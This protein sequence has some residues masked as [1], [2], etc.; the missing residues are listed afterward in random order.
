MTLFLNRT[1]FSTVFIIIII[2]FLFFFI[3]IFWLFSYIFLFT[4][5]TIFNY[6]F[7]SNTALIHCALVAKQ[8][9]PH[10]HNIPSLV[11]PWN[12]CC[13]FL[14]RRIETALCVINRLL[15]YKYTVLK[16]NG[17]WHCQPFTLDLQKQKYESG[18]C[19]ADLWSSDHKYTRTQS[20][21]QQKTKTF[22]F[23]SNS[24]ACR[25]TVTEPG[26]CPRV[27][28]FSTIMLYS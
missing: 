22:P 21:N 14:F 27:Q 24:S 25:L 13:M 5:C 28:E 19:P 9:Q 1:L 18:D 3:I 12:I 20:I 6:A 4:K 11:P 15:Y 2:I 26:C 7:F 17:T 8:L 23:K 16:W 10:N